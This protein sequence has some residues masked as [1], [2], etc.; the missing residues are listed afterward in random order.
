MPIT[1]TISKGPLPKFQ[2]SKYCKWCV[3]VETDDPAGFKSEED[4]PVPLQWAVDFSADT[5]IL[6]PEKA[7]LIEGAPKYSI[8]PGADEGTF[9][10]PGQTRFT[11]CFI[12]ACKERDDSEM[13]LENRLAARGA[14]FPQAWN[15]VPFK[16]GANGVAKILGPA[17]K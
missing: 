8:D 6:D 10:T 15:P 3:T 14:S 9:T 1:V 17:P 11:I 12:A 4:L 16:G 2:P 13:S 5:D 7:Q